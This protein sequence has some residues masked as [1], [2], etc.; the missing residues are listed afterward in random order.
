MEHLVIW[1]IEALIKALTRHTRPKPRDLV[2]VEP[3][4][5][6]SPSAA[7]TPSSSSSAVWADYRRKQAAIEREMLAKSPTTQR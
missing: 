1:L 2:G 5:T 6:P 3:R 4:S 7:G